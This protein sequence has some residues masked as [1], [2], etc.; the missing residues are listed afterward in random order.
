M[1]TCEMRSYESIAWVILLPMIR[2]VNLPATFIP[3]EPNNAIAVLD[4]A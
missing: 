2:R 1:K 3:L 4:N